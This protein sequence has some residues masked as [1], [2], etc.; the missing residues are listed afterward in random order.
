[1][2]LPMPQ[3]GYRCLFALQDPPVTVATHMTTSNAAICKIVQ[4][5]GSVVY[6]SL[7][8]WAQV[9][10]VRTWRKSKAEEST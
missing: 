5:D 2:I 3:T 9:I 6:E 4:T 1:M 7:N 10:S 8:S